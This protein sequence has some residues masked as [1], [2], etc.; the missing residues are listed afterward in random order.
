MFS[1][2]LRPLRRMMPASQEW[3]REEMCA[4]CAHLVEQ[5]PHWGFKTPSA[6]AIGIASNAVVLGNNE[7]VI[8]VD[9]QSGKPI[10]SH[11][12]P[13]PVVPWG[14]AI[15]NDGSVIVTL[16]DGQVVCIGKP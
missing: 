2:S 7:G 10:W 8:A 16:T 9:I 6:T 13:A 15:A 11:K 5:E 14:L 12:L 4:S 1:F 3:Y